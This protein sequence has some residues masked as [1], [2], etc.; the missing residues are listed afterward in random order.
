MSLSV[1]TYALCKKLISESTTGIKSITVDEHGDLV[2]TLGD[3]STIVV[4]MPIKVDA[5]DIQYIDDFPISN[6]STTTIYCK[7]TSLVD[8]VGNDIYTQWMYIN[9]SWR[10]IGKS[11]TPLASTSQAGLIKL[12]GVSLITNDQG[13]TEVSTDFI[14]DQIGNQIG[15]ISNSDVDDLFN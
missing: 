11:G 13:E 5:I 2:F 10:L 4:D 15:N 9:N 12:D 3:G 8:D 6:I 14:E 7:K 1:V